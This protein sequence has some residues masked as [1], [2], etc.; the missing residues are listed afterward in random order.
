VRQRWFE[1][2]RLKRSGGGGWQIIRTAG[3][4]DCNLVLFRSFS[5]AMKIATA[6]G[7]VAQLGERSVRNA[8]VRGSI[9]LISTKSKSCDVDIV[10]KA[11]VSGPFSFQIHI[12]PQIKKMWAVDYLPVKGPY[13]S[14]FWIQYWRA[15]RFANRPCMGNR[16]AGSIS[17]RRVPW[18]SCTS[19]LLIVQAPSRIL[20]NSPK[21]SLTSGSSPYFP[22]RRLMVLPIFSSISRFFRMGASSSGGILTSL[23]SSG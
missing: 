20:N 3:P 10:K 21:A 6:N 22:R 23:A 7:D 16:G 4:S 9:P 8:E 14:T 1:I 11:R 15:G 13:N 19:L 2:V 18:D 5:F 17:V 12:G